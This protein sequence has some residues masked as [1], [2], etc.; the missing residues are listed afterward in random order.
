M[1]KELEDIQ[2]PVIIPQEVVESTS[3]SVESGPIWKAPEGYKEISPQD[4]L[5]K[6]SE[7]PPCHSLYGNYTKIDPSHGSREDSMCEPR[8]TTYTVDF[9]GTLD[10][11]HL[12][13]PLHLIPNQKPTFNVKL[14][15]LLAI[16]DDQDVHPGL[17]NEKIPSDHVPLMVEVE[18]V[19]RKLKIHDK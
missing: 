14:K 13:D 6:F 3:I 4:L 11:I 18:I 2:P 10:Y 15:K 9:K 12:I 5:K 1:I 19:T 7:Y 8:W 17:P 16:P